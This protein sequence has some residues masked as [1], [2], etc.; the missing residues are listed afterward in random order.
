[1]MLAGD[2][3]GREEALVA[4]GKLLREG[5]VLRARRGLFEVSPDARYVAEARRA[6]G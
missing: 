3:V 1:M 5:S 2:R 4:F 6:R